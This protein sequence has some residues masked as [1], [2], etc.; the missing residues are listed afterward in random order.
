MTIV[1]T[2]SF[3]KHI[4]RRQLSVTKQARQAAFRQAATSQGSR[5]FS[6][7]NQQA[8]DALLRAVALKLGL[9]DA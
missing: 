1:N 7:M 8:K 4:A 5:V 9:I 3:P 2:K 6:E